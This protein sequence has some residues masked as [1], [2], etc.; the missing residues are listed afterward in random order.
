MRNPIFDACQPP[1]LQ[2][3]H[4]PDGCRRY[5]PHGGGVMRVCSCLQTEVTGWKSG[6]VQDEK[7]LH[8]FFLLFKE[9]TSFVAQETKESR[10]SMQTLWFISFKLS[11]G[12]NHHCHHLSW[13]HFSL[14]TVFCSAWSPATFMPKMSKY[15]AVFLSA[16]SHGLH[17]R[18]RFEC[19]S[20]SHKEPA[21]RNGAVKSACC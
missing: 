17:S 5:S 16:D 18:C 9:D 12:K 2:S 1:P 8:V 20:H 3:F 15:L 6:G 10:G 7:L 4:A 19:R 21:K 11:R 14:K 13:N